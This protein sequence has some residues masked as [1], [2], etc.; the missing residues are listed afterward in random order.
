MEGW[1]EIARWAECERMARP[2]IVFEVQNAAGQS[3]LTRCIV[4]LPAVPHDWSGPPQRFRAVEEAPARRS[5]PMPLP[6]GG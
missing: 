2:G 6:R 5:T 4:P 1:L 3:L